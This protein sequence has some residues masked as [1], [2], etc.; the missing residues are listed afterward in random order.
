MTSTQQQPPQPLADTESH[1]SPRTAGEKTLIATKVL[2]TVKWFNVKNGYGFINRNDEE[3]VVFVHQ[4]AIKNNNPRKSIRSVG[5]GETVEFDVVQGEKGAEAANV[6][7][8][9]G[10]P[11]QGSKYAPDSDKNAYRYY[12]RNRGPPRWRDNLD[13]RQVNNGEGDSGSKGRDQ[14][15]EDAPAEGEMQQEQRPPVAARHHGRR[16]PHANSQQGEAAEAGEVDENQGANPDQGNKASMRQGNYNNNRGFQSS[17]YSRRGTGPRHRWE[18]E[19]GKES[20]GGEEGQSHHQ[21]PRRNRRQRSQAAGGKPGQEGKA[22]GDESS[23]EKASALE[24][25]QAV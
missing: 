5:D 18:G 20:Q 4:R 15:C 14:E 1:G 3:G 6:T 10:I 23:V 11:V 13:N 21:E 2:G 7:G 25:Q 22:G 16:P 19:E 17:R 8:P 24:A 12:P 9:D